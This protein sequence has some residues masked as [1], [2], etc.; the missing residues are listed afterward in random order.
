MQPAVILQPADFAELMQRIARLEAA[1][2]A[3]ILASTAPPDET[4]TTAR[5]AQ[6]IGLSTDALLRARRAGRIVGVRLNE[7]DW[8]FRRSV[9]DKYPRRCHR[10]AS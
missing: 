3:R 9:L 4:L 8:G 7:K 1:E 5:A 10:T 2:Q 6:Y